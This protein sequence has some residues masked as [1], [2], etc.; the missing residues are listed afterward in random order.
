MT[1]PGIPLEIKT[2]I[3]RELSP[4]GSESNP[5][6]T[7][8]SGDEK[9]AYFCD[10]CTVCLVWPDTIAIIRQIIFERISLHA[11]D[12][13]IDSSLRNLCQA[14]ENDPNLS[15]FVA[16][17]EFSHR[18]PTA[19]CPKIHLSFPLPVVRSSSRS[20]PLFPKCT[21]SDFFASTTC[22]S[23]MRPPSS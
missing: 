5:R 8:V 3:I 16:I 7:P 1:Q 23:T 20:Y 2:L 17:L 13:H 12:R 4:Y 19:R 9:A 10:L 15:T 22:I 14:L 11:N 21:N 18:N 6:Y